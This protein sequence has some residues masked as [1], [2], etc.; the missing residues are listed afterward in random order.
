VPE[1]G[2]P[3]KLVTGGTAAST[4]CISTISRKMHRTIFTE[5][6]MTDILD[7]VEPHEMPLFRNWFVIRYYYGLKMMIAITVLLADRPVDGDIFG[8][9]NNNTLIV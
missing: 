7:T 4:P 9:Y 3:A 8:Q 2:V 5:F 6:L 1:V